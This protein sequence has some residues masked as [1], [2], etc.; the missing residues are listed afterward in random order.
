MIGGIDDDDDD[1]LDGHIG[2]PGTVRVTM[3][4]ITFAEV[5]LTT[6]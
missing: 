2:Y 4:G 6:P 5:M 3:P 1:D